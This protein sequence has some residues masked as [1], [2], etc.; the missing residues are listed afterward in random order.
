LCLA[1][2]LLVLATGCPK[3]KKTTTETAEVK[4]KVLFQGK[5]LPGGRVTFVDAD[6]FAG[7]ANIEENGEY[8]VQAPVGPVKIGVDNT[9][10]QRARGKPGKT[11][12]L[13]PKRPGAEEPT[14]QPGHFVSI[15]GKYSNP[16]T[17]GLTYTV[18]KGPQT[19]EIK[20]E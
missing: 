13:N 8:T 10:L 11:P 16:E 19:H 20:L 17:S 1:L 15:P 2:G 9:M 18:Q 5:G 14:T 4:G 3:K 12:L 6:G 7:S